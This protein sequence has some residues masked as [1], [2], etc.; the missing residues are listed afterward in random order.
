M[1]MLPVMLRYKSRK[2]FQPH[3]YRELSSIGDM[4]KVSNPSDFPTLLPHMFWRLTY[5]V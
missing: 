2:S 3:Y 4:K 1:P 5:V